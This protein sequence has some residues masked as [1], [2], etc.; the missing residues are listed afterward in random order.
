MST[1]VDVEKIWRIHEYLFAQWMGAW[2]EDGS[3]SGPISDYYMHGVDFTI[4]FYPEVQQR[5]DDE[6]NEA[7]DPNQALR[8]N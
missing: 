1:K 5:I 7:F 4:R 6:F 2:R 3:M 8:S